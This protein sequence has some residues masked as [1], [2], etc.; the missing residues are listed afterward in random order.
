MPPRLN[1]QNVKYETYKPIAFGGTHPKKCQFIYLSC[2]IAKPMLKFI[3]WFGE[4]NHDGVESIVSTWKF[5][6]FNTRRNKISTNHVLRKP[7]LQSYLN[8]YL[9][10]SS[11]LEFNR[12]G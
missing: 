8:L 6:F 5:H 9:K 10:N 2:S 11:V 1:Q 4:D 3:Y 12:N 7:F